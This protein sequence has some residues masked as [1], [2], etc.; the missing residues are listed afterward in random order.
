MTKEEESDLMTV[1][2]AAQERGVTPDAVRK[3][4]RRGRLQA[5]TLYGRLLVH[6]SEVMNFSEEKRGPR[7]PRKKPAK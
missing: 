3:L 1:G 2:E 4:I 7:G 6:R 5:V